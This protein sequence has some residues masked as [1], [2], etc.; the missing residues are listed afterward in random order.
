MKERHV[1]SRPQNRQ[2]SLPPLPS[3]PHIPEK[4][5]PLARE[6][7]GKIFVWKKKEKVWLGRGL[8]EA[9]C[10]H[11]FP[12]SVPGI[13][14]LEWGVETESFSAVLRGQVLFGK[15]PLTYW[16]LREPLNGIIASRGG[17]RKTRSEE[18]NSWFSSASRL[19][20]WD[21][22]SCLFRSTPLLSI[23]LCFSLS[24]F[25]LLVQPLLS[26]FFSRAIGLR[27]PST[28]FQAWLDFKQP[29]S[30]C[31]ACLRSAVVKWTDAT[32]SSLLSKNY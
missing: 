11:L 26:S 27:G 4:T 29:R 15:N 31:P 25:R 32:N 30:S 8:Y 16:W 6:K 18:R 28:C 19:S 1:Q 7:G 22:P 3:P 2:T 12:V 10:H 9:M 23:C 17:G 24:L 21:L 13:S 5:H 14:A 20:I